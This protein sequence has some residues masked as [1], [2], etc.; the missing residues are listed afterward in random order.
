MLFDTIC[1]VK[2]PLD[3][4]VSICTCLK[5]YLKKYHA[6]AIAF[7]VIIGRIQQEDTP[8]L[9]FDSGLKACQELI[10]EQRMA[11]MNS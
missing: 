1:E 4:T 9:I 7:L 6:M 10:A 8:T 3:R 5:N 2:N 11:N